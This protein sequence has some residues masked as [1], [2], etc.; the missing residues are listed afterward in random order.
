MSRSER[1]SSNSERSEDRDHERPPGALSE[2][3]T[4]RCTIRS[5]DKSWPTSSKSE[6]SSANSERSER[7]HC[8]RPSGSEAT[9]A[10]PFPLPAVLVEPFGST[11]TA[12][13]KGRPY[14]QLVTTV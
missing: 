2:P 14:D 10:S 13:D 8:E 4:A 7:C 11:R 9:R 1:S 12:P 6:R 5:P 3:A